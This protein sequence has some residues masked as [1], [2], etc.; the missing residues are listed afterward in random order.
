MPRK[1]WWK[2][3]RFVCVSSFFES[4]V[5]R[6]IKRRIKKHATHQS[7]CCYRSFSVSFCF[8]FVFTQFHYGTQLATTWTFH[9]IQHEEIHI[10]GQSTLNCIEI[11]QFRIKRNKNER[12][13]LTIRRSNGDENKCADVR[14]KCAIFNKQSNFYGDRDISGFKISFPAHWG[15]GR[16]GGVPV[17]PTSDLLATISMFEVIY[18][19]LFFLFVF[20]DPIKSEIVPIYFMRIWTLMII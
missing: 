16:H 1:F 18:L 19:F 13:S 17:P 3:L 20:L 7:I 5:C 15:V 12:K 2:L 6:G 8:R 10:S 14:K 11:S 4:Y 9:K